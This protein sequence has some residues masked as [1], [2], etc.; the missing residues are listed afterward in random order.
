MH[1][2]IEQSRQIEGLY[3]LTVRSCCAWGRREIK[4]FFPNAVLDKADVAVLDAQTEA[5]HAYP[6]LM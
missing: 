6:H 3:A 2:I 4:M 5:E 1:V